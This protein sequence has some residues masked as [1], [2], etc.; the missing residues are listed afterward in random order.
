MATMASKG[1][2]LSAVVADVVGRLA[3][4][5]VDEPRRSPAE[6]EGGPPCVEAWICEAE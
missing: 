4:S 6:S 2:E 5:A 1:P 3:K